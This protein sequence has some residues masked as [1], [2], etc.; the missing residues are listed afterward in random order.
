L[1]KLCELG[2]ICIVANCR[3]TDREY[4]SEVFYPSKPNSSLFKIRLATGWKE[5]LRVVGDLTATGFYVV[6]IF[7]Y[8]MN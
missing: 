4:H 6:N 1:L 5:N 2:N 8:A 7:I 3:T